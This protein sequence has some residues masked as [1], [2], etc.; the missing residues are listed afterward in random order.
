MQ[1]FPFDVQ[2][3]TLEFGSWTYHNKSMDLAIQDN[4]FDYWNGNKAVKSQQAFEDWYATIWG[5]KK[6]EVSAITIK[7]HGIKKFNLCK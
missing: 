6:S 2:N 5:Y 4:H 3:C 7:L 1:M